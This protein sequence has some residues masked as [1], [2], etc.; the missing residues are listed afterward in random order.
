MRPFQDSLCF[1]ISTSVSPDVFLSLFF[2]PVDRQT[3]TQ[4]TMI[5]TILSHRLYHLVR[6]H[7]LRTPPNTTGTSQSRRLTRHLLL[8]PTILLPLN[9][10]NRA[11][12]QRL[13]RQQQQQRKAT[14]YTTYNH[15]RHRTCPE[16]SIIQILAQRNPIRGKS[17]LR[18]GL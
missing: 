6:N 16:Q 11:I 15:Q 5:I 14:K 3:K 18:I 2:A 7:Q 10:R 13:V 1:I 17:L 8:T 12:L 4:V 9:L